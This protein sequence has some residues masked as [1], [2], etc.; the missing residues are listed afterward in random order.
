MN[1]I[2]R[3]KRRS[4]KKQSKLLF[5]INLQKRKIT[6]MINLL[7]NQRKKKKM[8]QKRAKI[9]RIIRYILHIMQSS[10]VLETRKKMLLTRRMKVIKRIKTKKMKKTKKI[11]RKVK[12]VRVAAVRRIVKRVQAHLAMQK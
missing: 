12:K 10:L 8:R 6:R 11:S 4:P 1:R 5:Q 9:I 3:L 2:K 7:I